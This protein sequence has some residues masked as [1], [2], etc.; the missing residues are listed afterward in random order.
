MQKTIKRTL[1][2]V[3]AVLMLCS[4]LPMVVGA[5][6]G[7]KVGDTVEYGSYPQ[8]EIKDAAT[9]AA[10]NALEADWQSYGYYSGTG[11]RADGQMTAGNYMQYCDVAYCGQKYRGVV[12]SLY[13]P[14]NTYGT[15][16]IGSSI[17]DENGYY[18]N[19][20]Y[21]FQYEPLQWRVLDPSTGLV[22][23]ETVIDSQPYKNYVLQTSE[24][25]EY[26]YTAYWG[27]AGKTHY[28]N[29]Y[30]ESS[31]RQW[32]NNDFYIAAFTK[33]QQDG[34]RA[35]TLDNSA[36]E[37][38]LAAYDSASTTDKVFLLSYGDMRNDA[39][40]FHAD[41]FSD[42]RQAQGSDYAKCQGLFVYSRN[43]CSYWWLRSAGNI[44][45]YACR[46]SPDGTI[47][48]GY[49]VD[50][51]DVGIRPAM[52]MNLA[53]LSQT[54]TVTVTTEVTSDS[55]STVKGA[56]TYAVG[57]TVTLTAT[58]KGKEFF[59]SW[60]IG[61]KQVSTETPYTF[62]AV[63]D[64]TVRAVFI[65]AVTMIHSVTVSDL[66]LQYKASGKLTPVVTVDEGVTYMLTYGGFDSSIISVDKDGNVTTVKGK[67]G[68]T[69][70]TVTATDEFG[71]VEK[72]NCTVTVKY[73]WWQVLIRIFLFGFIWY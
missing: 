49:Y 32:L 68:T 16:S 5:E 72:A 65:H 50:E 18:L 1:A 9:I 48:G 14:G 52:R 60:Y 15:H 40:G 45:L 69:T 44:S 39:Y 31:L 19:T 34:I 35:T 13:R 12:F 29:N 46:F 58:A 7:Y 71:N 17:Q 47:S 22:L 54:Q 4:A 53:N 64:V 38:F 10:L 57:E 28:A 61:D 66:T 67:T 63:E 21:W 41:A 42:N 23:C 37:S 70:V 11:E 43:D 30:A 25:D 55:G 27:D 2:M 8:T 26:G 51:T 20:T 56:G 6:V 59:D 24:S 36:Y 62:T 3:L 33:A 73:A